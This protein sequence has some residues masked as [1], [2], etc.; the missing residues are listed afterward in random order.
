MYRAVPGGNVSTLGQQLEELAPD[1]VET[2]C[3]PVPALSAFVQGLEGPGRL[4]EGSRLW[5]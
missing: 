1:G 3:T 5:S 4:F 2:V